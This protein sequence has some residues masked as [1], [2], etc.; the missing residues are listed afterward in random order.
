MS[1]RVAPGA[2]SFPKF[3]RFSSY[4]II[5]VAICGVKEIC[6]TIMNWGKRGKSDYY[7][8]KYRI[9]ISV[10][11]RNIGNGNLAKILAEKDKVLRT[12]SQDHKIKKRNHKEKE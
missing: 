9:G 6:S 7:Y 11:S 2:F 1:V 3:S 5:F 4:W 10:V 12:V 8:R